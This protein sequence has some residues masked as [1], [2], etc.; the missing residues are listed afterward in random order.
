MPVEQKRLTINVTEPDDE[1][2]DDDEEDGG[3][4]CIEGT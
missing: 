3:C 2:D 4:G 1:D